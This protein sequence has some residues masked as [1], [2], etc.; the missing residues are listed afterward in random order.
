MK[1]LN[2]FLF[3]LLLALASCVQAVTTYGI[4]DTNS[5]PKSKYV[6]YQYSSGEGERYRAVLLKNPESGVEIV[7]YSVQI[8][9]S[10]GT[11]EEALSFMGKSGL[12]RNVYSEGIT[13]K[14]RLIGYLLTFGRNIFAKESI[15]VDLYE[16][17]GKIYFE[18]KEKKEDY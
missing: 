10:E 1:R 5:I 8:T 7:P 16:R 15:E 17:G 9:T 12:S 11:P 18:V 3:V 2:V 4:K 13:Y 14:G 6:L